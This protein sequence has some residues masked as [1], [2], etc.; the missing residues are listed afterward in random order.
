MQPLPDPER[1][2]GAQELI[3]QLCVEL[4]QARAESAHVA[5]KAA[6][7]AEKLVRAVEELAHVVEEARQA[8][9][10]AG[11]AEA[12]AARNAAEL[13]RTQ[14][15]LGRA[16]EENARLAARVAELEQAASA[17]SK[18]PENSSVPPSSTP[19]ANV[20]K[21]RRRRKR[22]GRP[23]RGRPL[24]PHPDHHVKRTL[25]DCPHC[26]A[27]LRAVEQKPHAV[28]ERIELPPVRPEV[29]R[30]VLH[31]GR[32]PE[33]G[34]IVVAR[35]P[36]GLERGSPFGQSIA[37][38][39]LYLHYTQAISLERL[40]GLFGEVFGLE[41]SEGALV[42]IF[43]RA[44]ERVATQTAA[45]LERIRASRVICSDETSARVAGRT[46]WEWV[47][48]GEGAVLHELAASRAKSV[49][50]RVMAGARPEVWV[51]DL[52]GSQQGHG[53][54]AQVCLA[55]QVRDVQYAIDAGDAIFAPAMLE[56]LQRAVHLGRKRAQVKDRT[57]QRHR[58]ELLKRLAA[59]LELEPTQ[60]DG[61]RLRKR[62]VKVR[63]QLL[64]FMS[65][66]EVPTTNN[67]S[68]QALRLSAVFRKVTNGFRV[69][70]G[71][72]LYG[73]VRTVVATGRRQGFT[74]LAALRTTL[75]GGS[76]LVPPATP[77]AE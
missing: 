72:E 60:A 42:N 71:A 22:K 39:A 59:V 4:R 23:G 61:I 16:Q 19:K 27:N 28:Y 55:H 69:E 15:E 34:K 41:I 10:A 11:K 6:R 5:E 18:T 31:G 73:G 47:F 44:R 52:F 40:R 2:S 63:E 74:A 46:W 8:K 57:M 62:Y 14:A 7:V 68:E 67:V 3:Q 75:E 12:A 49:P 30:V 45:V 64:V 58:R 33:C 51:A 36:P 13:A 21:G 48:V 24:H 38:L 43:R 54:Q 77:A 70:W 17:P 26:G 37:T 35:P 66:R 56:F 50:E 25:A 20:P 1:W 76:I 65:D 29:T 53:E 32:C 9:A